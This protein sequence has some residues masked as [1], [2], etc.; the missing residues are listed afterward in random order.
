[1]TFSSLKDSALDHGPLGRDGLEPETSQKCSGA[2]GAAGRLVR[3][4]GCPAPQL[5]QFALNHFCCKFDTHGQ[6]SAMQS[7]FLIASHSTRCS[8]TVILGCGS[9]CVS[10]AS[11]E[12]SDRRFK[13]FGGPP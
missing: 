9:C 3:W 8:F 5:I 6:K 7:C 2:R 1:M 10:E 4:G 12:F 11:R 13:S